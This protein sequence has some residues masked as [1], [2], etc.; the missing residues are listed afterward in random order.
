MN[1]DR[2]DPEQVSNPPT[3]DYNTILNAM[4]V[5]VGPEGSWDWGYDTGGGRR[6]R[7]NFLEG[8]STT[9]AELEEKREGGDRSADREHLQLTVSYYPVDTVRYRVLTIQQDIHHIK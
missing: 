1:L 5:T 2:E 4:P 3:K 8:R 6:G 7:Q 9:T